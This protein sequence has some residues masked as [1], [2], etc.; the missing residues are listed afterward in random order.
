M[1]GQSLPV[2]SCRRCARV[3]PAHR[4]ALLSL[5]DDLPLAKAQ[6]RVSVTSSVL[7]S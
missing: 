6:K 2:C 4:A 5:M 7:P 3:G 1:D